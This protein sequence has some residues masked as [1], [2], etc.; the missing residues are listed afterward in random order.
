M[1]RQS[2]QHGVMDMGLPLAK[3]KETVMFRVGF[4]EGKDEDETRRN[5]ADDGSRPLGW[6]A[7]YPAED[8]AAEAPVLPGPPDAPLFNMGAVARG[9][10]LRTEPPT[11]PVVL[12]SHGTG[13]AATD[14]G[15]LGHRLAAEGFV[16]V[17]VN[18]HGNTEVE[19][20]R[21][22]GF[23]CWWER[24]LDLTAVFDRL[25]RR[26][27]FADRLDADRVFAAG[28]SLGGYT[29]LSLLGAITDIDL[30]RRWGE[31]QSTARGPREFP[32]LADHV[33]P[34]LETSSVFR[35]SWKRHSNSCRD[36]RIKRAVVFAPAPPIHSFT[37]QS[38]C[39]LQVPVKIS[40]GGADTE[41]PAGSCAGWLHEHVPDS[42][43]VLLGA[44]VGHYV[45]LCES[46]EAGRSLRPDICVDAPDVERRAVHDRMAALALRHFLE[47]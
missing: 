23:L 6:A 1:P 46:T 21:P 40:V 27:L 17:G 7:W 32:D 29:I 5:W 3:M 22:E 38:L 44:S 19:P 8:G 45:F 10:R 31:G 33:A 30:F 11:F 47:P 25:S 34:L 4:V 37:V 26:G 41:A 24:P 35:A 43:L 36:A 14:L 15:W 18:H 39:A 13:G 20:Y 28:F 2:G 42:S 16:V 9:A 12:L